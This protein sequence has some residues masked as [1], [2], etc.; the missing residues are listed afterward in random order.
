MLFLPALFAFLQLV[1]LVRATSH[2]G[3]LRS[4]HELEKRAKKHTPKFVLYTDEDNSKPPSA[5]SIPNWN[6]YM[7]PFWTVAHGPTDHAK[8]WTE[9]STS[10]RKKIMKEYQDKGIKIMLGAMGD[11]DQPTSK[12]FNP[13]TSAEKLAA[14]VK[15]YGFDGVDIDYED[16][17]AFNHG[18]AEAWVISFQKELR[19]KLGKSY[20]ITHA[21]VAPWFRNDKYYKGGGY[22]KIHKEVGST[23]DWYHVQYYNQG[24]EYTNCE[25]LIHKSKEFPGTAVLELS[26]Q[27]PSQKLILSKVGPKSE[28]VNGGF[29]DEKTLKSC[30][31]EGRKGKWEGG[32]MIWDTPKGG[33]KSFV[34]S[35]WGE[36]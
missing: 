8:M 19:A 5:S 9:M 34:K 15:K 23:I 20:I 1:S 11:Q 14:F 27:I 36:L 32:V 10:E 28:A 6:T 16:F 17:N 22:S 24:T 35:I 30:V 25:T 18:T 29:M 3:S 13:K 33:V 2:S 21:P 7:I 12:K 31:K 4:E 26:K